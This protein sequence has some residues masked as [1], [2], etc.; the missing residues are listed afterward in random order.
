MFLT[1]VSTF[2]EPVLCAHKKSAHTQCSS[3]RRAAV[4]FIKNEM[5][6]ANKENVNKLM[7]HC[8]VRV[9]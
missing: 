9:L 8:A 5:H 6:H 7:L 4:A 1:V 2:H 3:M